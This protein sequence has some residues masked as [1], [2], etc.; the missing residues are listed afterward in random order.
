MRYPKVL[1]TIR[2]SES[3]KY[4]AESLADRYDMPL[5]AL[6]RQLIDQE[7]EKSNAQARR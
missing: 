2:V 5:G 4:R 1:P 7:W 6:I 3:Q